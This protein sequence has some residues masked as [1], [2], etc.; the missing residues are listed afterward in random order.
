MGDSRVR[1]SCVAADARATCLLGAYG[2]LRRRLSF[3][4]QRADDVEIPR[5]EMSIELRTKFPGVVAR[6]YGSPGC[7]QP[8]PRLVP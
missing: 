3:Q 2:L 1:P 5:R 4:L 8:S 6:P 7:G